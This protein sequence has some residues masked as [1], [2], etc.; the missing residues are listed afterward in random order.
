ML[1]SGKKKSTLCATEKR[2]ILTLVLS[3]KK[4]LNKT[5]NNNPT[6]CKLNGRSLRECIIYKRK[7]NMIVINNTMYTNSDKMTRKQ[8]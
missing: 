2:N 1:D 6:P 4:F 3:E 8:R 7:Y 5:K